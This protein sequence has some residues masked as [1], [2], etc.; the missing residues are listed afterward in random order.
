MIKLVSL[1]YR[2]I[3]MNFY[4]KKLI[5]IRKPQKSENL[6][7]CTM[8]NPF[9]VSTSFTTLFLHSFC[10]ARKCVSRMAAITKKV[11]TSIRIICF[12][13]NKAINEL[14]RGVCTKIYSRKKLFECKFHIH[15]GTKSMLKILR[16]LIE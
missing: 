12:W 2:N 1:L 11:L 8:C 10:F 3:I 9:R 6:L 4:F 5:S 7:I 16:M 14:N 15:F 13:K